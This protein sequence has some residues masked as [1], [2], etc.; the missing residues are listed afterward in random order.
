MSITT[1][2][3]KKNA[4]ENNASVIRRFMRRVQESGILPKV[5][6]NRYSE[7]S[8]SKL[9]QKKSALKKMKRRKETER[10]KKL[11]KYVERGR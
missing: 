1:I 4:N 8:P 11:G 3:I 9:T 6:G 10:L 5:K 7:R 2:E